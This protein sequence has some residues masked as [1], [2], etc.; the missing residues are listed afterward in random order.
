MP[1]SQYRSFVFTINNDIF[2]DLYQLMNI[3]CD[4]LLFSFEVGEQGT[5]HIQGYIHFNGSNKYTIKSISNMIPRA[6]IMPANGTPQEQYKYI[7]GPYEK[8]GKYKPYNPDHYEFGELPIQGKITWDRITQ[9]MES[10]KDNFHLYNQYRKSYQLVK[11]S[12]KEDKKRQLCL[13]SEELIIYFATT[14]S[15]YTI[16][17]Y[18]SEYDN[19][20]IMCVLTYGDPSWLKMWMAGFPI[21]QRNG[22]EISYVDPTIIVIMYDTIKDYNYLIKKYIDNISAVLKS[23]EDIEKW[24]ELIDVGLE[25]DQ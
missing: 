2:Q 1:S 20:D 25:N 23:H 10:P 4:Y 22:Y 16:S 17:I 13:L 21:K 18:P 11:N 19:E 12:I 6:H 7:V 5:P 9:I 3:T 8:E 15:Q 14:F 24:H